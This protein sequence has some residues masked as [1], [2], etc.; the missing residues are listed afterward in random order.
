MLIVGLKVH[1]VNWTL[2]AQGRNSS[3]HGYLVGKPT[4]ASTVALSLNH[5]LEVTTLQGGFVLLYFTT[6]HVFTWMQLMFQIVIKK[7]RTRCLFGLFVVTNLDFVGISI[8]NLNV[9]T[10]HLGGVG[11][12]Q[13]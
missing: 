10:I 5:N 2:F 8:Q 7:R 3:C 9:N 11:K 1:I 12:I 6:K 13:A 4:G